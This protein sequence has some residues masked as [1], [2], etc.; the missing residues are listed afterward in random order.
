MRIEIVRSMFLIGACELL[1]GVRM[2]SLSTCYSQ[3]QP[4]N[5]ANKAQAVRQPP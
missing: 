3:D 1:L 4:E 5:L 2:D